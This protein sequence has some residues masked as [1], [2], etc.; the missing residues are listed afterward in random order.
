MEGIEAETWTAKQPKEKKKTYSTELLAFDWS[1]SS[2]TQIC[3][4]RDEGKSYVG[5][6]VWCFF[7]PELVVTTGYHQ[8]KSTTDRNILCF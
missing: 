8:S 4:D 5:L 2:P 1:D 7:S 6:E 3:E